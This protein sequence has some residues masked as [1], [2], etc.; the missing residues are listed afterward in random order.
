MICFSLILTLAALGDLFNLLLFR[1]GILFTV[2][3]ARHHHIS[4]IVGLPSPAVIRHPRLSPVVV[5]I[6]YPHAPGRHS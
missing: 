1:V 2:L 6:I 3:V 5:L 4:L